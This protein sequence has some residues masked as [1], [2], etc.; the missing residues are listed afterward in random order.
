M[1]NSEKISIIIFELD[2]DV[3]VVVFFQIIKVLTI[4]S[5]RENIFN[6]INPCYEEKERVIREAGVWLV[7]V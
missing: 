6:I 1:G 7:F 3:V 5:I 4:A 2:V